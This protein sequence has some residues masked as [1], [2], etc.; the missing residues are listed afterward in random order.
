MKLRF[1]LIAAL[2]GAAF[3]MF[4]A[5]PPGPPTFATEVDGS[6]VA[7]IGQLKF[8]NGTLTVNPD[9]S[10]SY[11]GAGSVTGLTNPLNDH[12][13]ITASYGITNDTSGVGISMGASDLNLFGLYQTVYGDGN[14]DFVLRNAVDDA[15]ISLF[16]GNLATTGPGIVLFGE[17]EGGGLGGTVYFRYGGGTAGSVAQ[18]TAQFLVQ[19]LS[20]TDT[21]DNAFQ[22]TW[23]GNVN[24]PLGWIDAANGFTNDTQAVG[25]VL[26]ADDISMWGNYLRLQGSGSVVGTRYTN[27]LGVA[28]WIAGLTGSSSGWGTNTFLWYDDVLGN[29][30]AVLDYDGAFYL[31]ETDT[32]TSP[33]NTSFSGLRVNTSNQLLLNNSEVYVAGGTDVPLADGGTGAS[34]SDPGAD[35]IGF[36]D[37]SAGA[38]TWLTAGSGLTIT[39]T[40]ITSIGGGSG[41]FDDSSDPV[42]LN[43]T[44]KDVSIG[45]GVSGVTAKVEIGGDDA[46][47]QLVIQGYTGDADDLIQ[48]KNAAGTT[49]FSVAGDGDMTMTDLT[50]NGNL[51][52]DALVFAEQSG[53]AASAG[54]GI[55]WVTNSAAT[56][57][58]FTDDADADHRIA[59]Y[60]EFSG[61]ATVSDS[62]SVSLATDSVDKDQLSASAQAL[63][64]EQLGS[65][66]TV[67]VSAS[68]G[69]GY[70]SVHYI[71]AAV[72]ITLPAVPSGGACFTFISTGANTVTIDSNASDLIILDGTTLDD[73]DSIDSPG[74]AG[75]IV[76]IIYY[77]ST[78]WFATSNGWSDGGPS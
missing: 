68:S 64:I 52:A 71:T 48:G 7:I 45:D 76:S 20:A 11:S 67:E 27:T 29:T 36:W 58:V 70:N 38:F 30:V 63:F 14:N 18:S 1:T 75:D 77:D 50:V 8:P 31:M 43:T 6:P 59:L 25:M 10:V 57:P 51:T 54:E 5:G 24:V 19:R 73:G 9:G 35:R 37:D 69:E 74:A 60:D 4:A 61:D 15:S 40:T 23:D 72:T 21:Y 33:I 49:V 41:A 28:S 66:H 17:D 26:N 13:D 46:Q 53:A 42:V 56:L 44:T 65:G 55:F 47:P 22:V 34:L 39:D 62:G 78:G 2:I 12:M 3:S 32:A 16:G